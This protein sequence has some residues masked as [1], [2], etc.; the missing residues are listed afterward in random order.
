MK[1]LKKIKKDIKFQLLIFILIIL[2]LFLI[3]NFSYDLLI[4]TV[5]LI[6]F[7]LLSEVLISKWFWIKKSLESA[8]ITW[9]ILS[10]II[11]PIWTWENY[12]ASGLTAIFAILLKYLSKKYLKLDSINPVV[13]WIFWVYFLSFIIWDEF[14]AIPWWQGASFSFF[15][16]ELVALLTLLFWCYMCYKLRKTFLIYS[17]LVGFLPLWLLLLWF[18]FVIW[19]MAWWTIYFFLLIMATDIKT[20]PIKKHHQITA[21]VFLWLA[22]AL[23]IKFPFTF[24]Y[25]F[26]LWLYNILVFAQK[27]GL[28]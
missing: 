28:Y 2:N 16:F 23:A 21:W 12:V 22:L 7:S 10:L 18:D 15:W 6:V 9:M 20:S 4:N 1:L 25:L 24:T 8:L 11:L 5:I 27:K 3:S 13:F 17:F 14:I 26:V 19:L